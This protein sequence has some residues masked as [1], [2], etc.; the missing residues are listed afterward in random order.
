MGVR[1][2]E[3]LPKE[4]DGNEERADNNGWQAFLWLDGTIWLALR[5]DGFADPIEKRGR[6][7]KRSDENA[8]VGEAELT[9]MMTTVSKVLTNA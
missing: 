5:L 8:D 2:Y 4:T 7:D 9:L 3:R 1:K 6:D